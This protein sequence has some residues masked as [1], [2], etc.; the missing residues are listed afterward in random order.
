MGFFSE[1]S[2]QTS[3]SGQR[4]ERLCFRIILAERAAMFVN[5]VSV[6]VVG[7]AYQIAANY[8]KQAGGIPA[9]LDIYQPLLD[10][11]VEDYRAGQKNKLRLANRAIARFEKLIWKLSGEFA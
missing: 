3:G 7:G 4:N 8:L 11:I 5:S 1:S 10:S 2:P 9:A 6:E